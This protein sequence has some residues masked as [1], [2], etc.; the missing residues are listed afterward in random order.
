MQA[1][2]LQIY[3]VGIV[4]ENKPLNTR[5]IE[6]TPMETLPL[7]GGEITPN[8]SVYSASAV[9]DKGAAYQVEAT[10]AATVKATWL[11]MHSSNRLTAPDVRRGETVVL[12]RFAD[13]DEFWWATLKDDLQLRKLETVI[14]AFSGTKDES[15]APDAT[16]TYFLEISTH[17][18]L[19]SFH[20][21]KADGEP[22]AYDVQFNTKDGTVLLTDDIGNYFALNSKERQLEMK[23]PDGTYLRIDK[24]NFM[25]EAPETISLKAKNITH[26]ATNID[27]K[28]TAIVQETSTL[29]EKSGSY[30]LSTG[31][32][33]MGAEGGGGS[34]NLQFASGDLK[35]AGISLVTHTHTEQGDGADVSTPK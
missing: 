29:S 22:F 20:T 26:Q 6:V 30:A 31:A 1:S 7:L 25:I 15:A 32:M 23:N 14:Y 35:V 18:K 3:S 21:S 33:T 27:I 19:V 9:D 11:P 2:K 4:A 24:K 12:Y 16:N 5:V 10:T 8:S 28:A 17:K 34:I 13:T